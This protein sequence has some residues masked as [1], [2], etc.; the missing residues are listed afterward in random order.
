MALYFA[1]NMLDIKFASLSGEIISKA[2]EAMTGEAAA[3]C[4]PLEVESSFDNCG[5][6]E[7]FC[8]DI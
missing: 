4:Q 6:F 7:L 1:N 8:D 2:Y 5:E 3:S